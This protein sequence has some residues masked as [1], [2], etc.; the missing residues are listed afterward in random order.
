MKEIFRRIESNDLAGLE[1]VLRRGDDPNQVDSTGEYFPL[2]A[3][4]WR[5][6]FGGSIDAIRLLLRFGAHLDTVDRRPDATSPLLAAL[7]D[8]QQEAA[9]IL[10]QAGADVNIVDGLGRSALR[11][12]VE[13]N[14]L[15]MAENLLKHGATKTI[16]KAGGIWPK[17]ALGHAVTNVNAKMVEKLLQYGADSQALDLDSRIAVTYLPARDHSNAEAWDEIKNLLKKQV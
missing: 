3:A 17:T 7:L 11:V 4:I 5:L 6:Y 1:L 13:M 10:V 16:N 12:S 15:E 8:D 14:D 9:N 2:H